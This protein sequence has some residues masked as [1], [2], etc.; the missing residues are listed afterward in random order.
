MHKDNKEKKPSL[1]SKIAQTKNGKSFNNG[2]RAVKDI[3][4]ESGFELVEA[5]LS[6]VGLGGLAPLIRAG[7]K[8]VKR[9]IRKDKAMKELEKTV[10]EPE[11]G[12]THK[13]IIKSTKDKLSAFVQSESLNPQADETKR[14]EKV[15]ASSKLSGGLVDNATTCENLKRIINPERALE[16]T[17]KESKKVKNVQLTL[18]FMD[19]RKTR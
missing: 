2:F 14:I 10:F 6:V 3:I 17:K 4:Q 1:F 11:D 15:I 12:S 13:D 18:P 5:G 19:T 7:E 16:E 8:I 9:G